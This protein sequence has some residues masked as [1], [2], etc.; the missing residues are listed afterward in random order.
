MKDKIQSLKIPGG[1]QVTGYNKESFTGQ[2][3]GPYIGPITVNEV[4]AKTAWESYK[5]EDTPPIPT[6]KKK[7]ARRFKVKKLSNGKKRSKKVSHVFSEEY[8]L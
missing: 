3:Y 6:K 1:R 8:I 5:I 7:A 2:A 4:D